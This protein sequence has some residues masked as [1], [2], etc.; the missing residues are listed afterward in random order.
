M[1]QQRLARYP[2]TR[3]CTCIYAVQFFHQS[4]SSCVH[5]HIYKYLTDISLQRM[6]VYIHAYF[7]SVSHT[8]V[9]TQKETEWYLTCVLKSKTRWRIITD[10]TCV[11]DIA[12]QSL[13][14][15]AWYTIMHHS[16]ILCTGN[17]CLKHSH[18]HT[19]KC[20]LR[21]IQANVCCSKVAY[22]SLAQDAWARRWNMCGILPCGSYP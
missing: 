17:I 9:V 19:D 13:A 18:P 14:E 15:G 21:Y 20:V 16:N 3:V 7:L 1:H 8:L 2:C 22:R 5:I 4:S 11:H 6:Q 12:N 10:D